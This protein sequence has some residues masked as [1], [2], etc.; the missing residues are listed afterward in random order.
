MNKRKIIALVLALAMSV[1]MLFGFAAC[2]G[3]K[4]SD[5]T[6]AANTDKKYAD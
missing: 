6:D 3:D 4:G 2:G 5:T 1:S